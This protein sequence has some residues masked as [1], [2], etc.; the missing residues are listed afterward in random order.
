MNLCHISRKWALLCRTC[1]SPIE[2]WNI[3]SWYLSPAEILEWWRNSCKRSSPVC[4]PRWQ[5]SE[6][7]PISLFGG[8]KQR[9]TVGTE[10]TDSFSNNYASALVAGSFKPL[11]VRQN[12]LRDHYRYSFLHVNPCLYGGETSR[13]DR[14]RLA[15]WTSEVY[16]IQMSRALLRCQWT[17]KSAIRFRVAFMASI[18][19]GQVERRCVGGLRRSK[20]HKV[21]VSLRSY[22]LKRFTLT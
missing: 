16:V 10:S 20:D 3:R 1:V 8:E 21:K 5:V 9:Q 2:P 17:R 4:G 18:M 11:L 15:Q 12:S 19:D 14:T 22:N 13:S 7:E 6:E